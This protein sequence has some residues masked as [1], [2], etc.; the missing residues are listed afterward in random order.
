MRASTSMKQH[1]EVQY[2]TQAMTPGFTGERHILY[3]ISHRCRIHE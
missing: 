1:L 2:G 3:R